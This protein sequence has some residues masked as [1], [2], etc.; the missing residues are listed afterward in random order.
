MQ[1]QA[2]LT[3]IGR[4][5]G[6][7]VYQ[8]RDLADAITHWVKYDSW[9]PPSRPHAAF[10]QTRGYRSAR[11]AAPS[12]Q[13]LRRHERSA[14]WFELYHRGRRVIQHVAFYRRVS[15]RRR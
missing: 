8:P 9:R 2:F 4:R 5:F 6:R 7:R 1:Q 11:P 10:P 3:E 15:A 14:M 13:A 12:A